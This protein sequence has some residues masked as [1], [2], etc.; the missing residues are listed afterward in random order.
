MS[1]REFFEKSFGHQL[2]VTAVLRNSGAVLGYV[3]DL[4]LIGFL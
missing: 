2:S 4:V 3:L 1:L